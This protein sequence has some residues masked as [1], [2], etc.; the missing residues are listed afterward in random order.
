MDHFMISAPCLA[1]LAVPCTAQ[2]P[3]A[4]NGESSSRKS[5]GSSVTPSKAVTRSGASPQC[6]FPQWEWWT[7]VTIP[8]RLLVNLDAQ[9]DYSTTR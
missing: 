3:R 8:P 1:L 5:E 7:N 9:S 2:K 4:V 6:T